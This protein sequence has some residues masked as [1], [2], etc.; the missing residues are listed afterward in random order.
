MISIVTQEYREGNLAVRTTV[1]TF[2]CIPIFKFRK[3]STN[4]W[5]VSQLTTIK[6]VTKVKGFIK[7]ETKD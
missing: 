5:L 4:N 1:I 7:H 2:L 3:T 6:E